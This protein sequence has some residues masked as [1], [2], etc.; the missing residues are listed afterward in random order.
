MFYD[1]ERK[2]K[3]ENCNKKKNEIIFD[4]NQNGRR[5]TAASVR[6]CAHRTWLNQDPEV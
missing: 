5:G 4:W 1:P 6:S 2:K 3:N